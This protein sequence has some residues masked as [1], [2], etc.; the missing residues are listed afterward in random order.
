MMHR[1][2]FLSFVVASLVVAP[3]LAQNLRKSRKKNSDTTGTSRYIFSQAMKQAQQQRWDALPIGELMGKLGVLLQGT[4]YVGG[5]LEADGPEV[6]RIDLTG[7]DC[8]TFF[9][10][11]LCMARVLQK[12]KGRLPSWNDFMNEVTFTRYRDGR[13]SDYTSRLH[14]TSEWIAD[15]VRK[16]VVDD[17]TPSLDGVPFP[18]SVGFM[19]ANPK[20]YKP[21]LNDDV[22]RQRMAGI[23]QQINATQRTYIPKDAVQA[24]EGRLQTG[25]I[26]CIT[27]N[28][29]GLDYSHTGLVYTDD[30]GVRHLLHASLQKKKVVVDRRLS[31]YL[32][33]VKS[34]TG[35]SIVRPRAV[36]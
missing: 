15:N 34:H 3:S 26:V 7:L 10:N 22:L 1:R 32:A 16:M 36:A 29:A 14:Y 24:I 25:D 6:C 12:S 13:L 2:S 9:E 35:V 18:L 20:Y 19:S 30:A 27:T 11:V 8:V 17:I 31:E 33:D 23:E 5:T 28:K 21:L 4:P